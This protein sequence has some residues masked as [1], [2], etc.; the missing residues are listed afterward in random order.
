MD[1]LDWH[2]I[3]G[4]DRS[5]LDAPFSLEKIKKVVFVFGHNKVSSPAGVSV[6]FFF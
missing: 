3:F 5:V 4:S 2:P 6:A 1:G